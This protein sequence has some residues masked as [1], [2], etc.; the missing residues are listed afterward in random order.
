RDLLW[1]G[2]RGVNGIDRFFKYVEEKSYKIQY[3]V[4]ASR[5]RGKTTCPTCEGTRLRKES[6][7]V[8]IADR[9]ITQLARMPLKDCLEFFKQ[10]KLD[11]HDSKIADRLLKE[12]GNRLQYLVD[13]GV[14]YLTMD[15]RSNTLSGG[16]TQ[17]ID[18]ATSL[19]SSLVG[20][21]YILDEPSIG[22]HPRDTQRL[23]QV[24]FKLRDLGNTVIVVEHDEE[25]MRTA[26][27]IIDMGPMA[28][29]HGGEVVF[30]GTHEQL[31]GSDGLTAKYL[32]GR[33]P[34]EIPCHRRKVKDR[35]ILR[36]AREH[37]LQSI[38]VAFPLSMHTVDTG[39]SGSGKPTLE[40]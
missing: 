34:N 14:G 35:I 8:K 9:D 3:R 10:L 40:K 24:L 18:L 19:G 21:M 11:E 17:R 36:G 2:A 7:Y 31:I 5:Y 20:S 33:M 22:L 16:E 12:I 28:G 27:H 13:V 25:V 26:D 38:D 32:T 6:R 23:I 29:T 1:K 30:S 15:R 4:L 37:N 39:V